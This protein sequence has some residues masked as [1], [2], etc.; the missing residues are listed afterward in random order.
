MT[1]PGAGGDELDLAA[2]TIVA[3]GVVAQV[4][5]Q[6]IQLVPVAKH[7]CALAQI[8][9]GDEGA[10]CVQLLA[11]HT[12]LG[13]V[14]QIDHFH[15][16]LGM[17]LA[18]AVQVRQLQDIVHQLDHPAGFYMNFP[19]KLGHIGGFGNAG[20]NEL[21]IAGNTGQRRFQFVADVGREILPHLLVVFPQQPVRVDALGKGDELPVGNVF[22]NV[23]EVIRHFQN[24][25]DKTAGQ[26]PG[27]Q[28]CGT[29]HQNAAQDDGGQGR[30]V[31]RPDG[32]RILGYTQDIAAGQQHGVI[33]GLVSHGLGIAAVTAYTLPHGLLD[34]RAGQVVFHLLV[35]GGFEHHTAIC[36]D[37]G[38]AQVSVDEH[39]ELI[40]RGKLLVSGGNQIGLMLQRGPC[41][42]P[43]R[44]VKNEETE[45]GGADQTDEAHEKQPVTDFFFHALRFHSS[46]PSSLSASL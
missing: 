16:G 29:H 33:V 1:V 30:V 42:F 21:R 10:L 19:T 9:Q 7:S 20:F 6:L 28:R 41:L 22:L 23:L 27:N 11:F 8:G 24:G 18:D 31:D 4:L 15:V 14:Q 25:L 32:L 34:L 17:G 39:G 37:Q 35:S 13:Y 40:R 46:S 45:H 43:E 12:I 36:R 44:F 3:D 26:Q 38:N 5:A 2:G